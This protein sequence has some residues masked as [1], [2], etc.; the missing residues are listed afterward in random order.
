MSLLKGHIYVSHGCYRCF[1]DKLAF[2]GF[3]MSTV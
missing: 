2:E 3:W 1:S